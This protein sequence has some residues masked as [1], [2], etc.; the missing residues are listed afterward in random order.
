MANILNIETSTEVCS[1]ALTSDGMVLEHREDYEGRN[2][3]LLLSGFIEEMMQYATPR[4]VKI[5]AVAVSIGPGSYTGLRIGLSEAK[6][7]CFGLDVPL[8]GIDTLKIL[9]VATMF[10]NYIDENSYYVPMIDA[11]RMEVF[12]GVYDSALQ[13]VMPARPVILTPDSFSEYLGQG[14]KLVF[15][16]NGA[17]KAANLIKHPDVVYIPGVKPAAVDMLALSEMAF[18]KGDFI[19]IAYSTPNYLKEFQATTPKKKI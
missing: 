5:D 8:I 9:V 19:D 12:A 4:G 6:G 14:R 2:H 10:G 11:R 15:V 1:V 16:G 18:R 17:E 13:E 3:A 7:L